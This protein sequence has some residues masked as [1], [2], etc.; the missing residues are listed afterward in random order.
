MFYETIKA[1]NK[2]GAAA[3]KKNIYSFFKNYQQHDDDDEKLNYFKL[4]LHDDSTPQL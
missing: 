2:N 3:L 1:N 4:T